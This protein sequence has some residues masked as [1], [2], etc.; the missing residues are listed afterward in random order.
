MDA[1]RKPA[2]VARFCCTNLHL[3]HWMVFCVPW[4]NVGVFICRRR[5]HFMFANSRWLMRRKRRRAFF[6][7]LVV[8]HCPRQ[9]VLRHPRRIV[10]TRKFWNTLWVIWDRVFCIQ[11]EL[12]RKMVTV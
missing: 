8:A 3:K 6:T 9:V 1:P 11:Q 2:L 10:F 7:M 12:P 4:K 5:T